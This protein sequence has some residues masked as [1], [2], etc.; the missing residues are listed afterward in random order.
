M[1]D[2]SAV[3]LKDFQ[4]VNHFYRHGFITSKIGLAASLRKSYL[5]NNDIAMESFFPKCFILNSIS[6]LKEGTK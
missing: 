4:I 1:K 6:R 2:A 3:E 5:W